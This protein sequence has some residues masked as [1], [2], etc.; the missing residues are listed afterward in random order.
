MAIARTKIFMSNKSQAIR[1]PK[2][3]ELPESLREVDIVAIGLKRII[4]PTGKSWDEW[5]DSP[6][7]SED[8]MASREQPLDQQREIF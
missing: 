1:L 8:F 7:V 6:D 5:F 4:T 2:A 3:V